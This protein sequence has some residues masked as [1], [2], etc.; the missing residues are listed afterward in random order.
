MPT[1]FLR[2]SVIQCFRFIQFGVRL[3]RGIGP[4]AADTLQPGAILFQCLLEVRWVRAIDHVVGRTLLGCLVH[5]L[6]SASQGL[7]VWQAP[8]GFNG[9]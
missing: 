1:Q 2:V 4:Y 9:E 5:Y 3:A 8:I 7:P 6:D